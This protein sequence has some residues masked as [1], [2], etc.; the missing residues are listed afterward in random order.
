MV[1]P[2]YLQQIANGRPH[3]PVLPASDQADHTTSHLNESPMMVR[4]E[5]AHSAGRLKGLQGVVKGLRHCADDL[6]AFSESM[7]AV[8][9]TLP[10]LSC[11]N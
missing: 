8:S 5:P 11:P 10:V 7:A 4:I 3:P 2:V 1:R 6:I 9:D